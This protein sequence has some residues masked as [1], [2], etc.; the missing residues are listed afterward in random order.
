MNR[1][2]RLPASSLKL[3]VFDVDRTLVR[4]TS[5]EMQLVRYLRTK[6]LLG[7]TDYCRVLMNLFKLSNGFHETVLRNKV[8]L[9]GIPKKTIL[10][11]LPDFF[12]TCLRP[13][14]SSRG[15]EWM[16]HLR[17][18]GFFVLLISGTL[19]FIVDY[20]VESLD[21]DEGAGSTMEIRDHVYTGRVLG[22][23][24]WLK[25]KLEILEGCLRG[26]TVDYGRSF[27]F[28]DSWADIPLLSRFGRP[29]A[30]NPGCILYWAA[31]IRGWKVIRG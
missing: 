10:A 28:A 21:A 18:R 29:V 31:M 15:M 5:C 9:H 26:R 23:L 4:R 8:Y 27:C 6:G 14:L 16:S 19:D 7:W 24:P 25:G 20:L 2:F 22:P 3:A 1:A 17:K 13:R 11:L 30:M 12:E